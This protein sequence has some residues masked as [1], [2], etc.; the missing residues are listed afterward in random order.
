MLRFAS[1]LSPSLE[2][3]YRATAEYVGRRLGTETELVV[4]TSLDQITW[5]EV[6][7]S[8]VCGY[9]YV[10]LAAGERPPQAIAAPVL[11]EPRYGGRPVYYSDVIVRRDDPMGR[12]AD[13]R[14]CH[15]CFNE[16]TSHSG[17]LTV[18]HHLVQLGETKSFFGCFEE[19]GFHLESMRLV[20]DGAY[21]A[22]A[23]D[24]HVLA[25][26]RREDPD[27]VARLKVIDTIGPSSIQPV[28]VGAHVPDDTREMVRG[29]LAVMH[30]DQQY[31]A[32]LGEALVARYAPVSDAAYDDIRRMLAT[33]QSA[34][35]LE[36]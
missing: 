11:T 2:S 25:V 6:D 7:V 33:V 15:W 12:F 10:V 35:L 29:A 21:E 23:I 5:G 9:P 34:G 13:L 1:F 31:A 4:G 26:A 36:A 14:G 24:S 8:F 20:A 17:C 22:S 32:V 30:S 28:V 3:F 19:A 18:L 16:P 27:L